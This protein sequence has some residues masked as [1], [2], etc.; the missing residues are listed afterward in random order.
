MNISALNQL[1]LGDAGGAITIEKEIEAQ[2]LG[3]AQSD[4]RLEYVNRL[5]LARLYRKCGELG[6]AERYYSEA[7]DT[8]SGVRP[9]TDL[10][11]V[12]VT[13]AILYGEQG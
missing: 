7:F 2:S 6:L 5:N 4:F 1:R 10:I 12:N 3:L 8:T 11:Y 9:V 13:R